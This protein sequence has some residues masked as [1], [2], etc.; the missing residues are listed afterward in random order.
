M[1]LKHISYCS[2]TIIEKLYCTISLRIIRTGIDIEC[3][4]VIRAVNTRFQSRCLAQRTESCFI[5]GKRILHFCCLFRRNY[6]Q[7]APVTQSALCISVLLEVRNCDRNLIDNVRRNVFRYSHFVAVC[8]IQFTY[9]IST[10]IRN[11][12]YSNIFCGERVFIAYL[13][14]RSSLCQYSRL[15]FGNN[16]L[17]T[18]CGGINASLIKR[19]RQRRFCI[20]VSLYFKA[21]G[22]SPL[23]SFC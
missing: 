8:I 6:R 23:L 12:R 11:R 10:L 20:I 2:F 14:I 15:P 22:R 3:N 17:Q 19:K 13:D 16:C 7:S 21:L 4:A 18:E 5:C 1:E 9:I